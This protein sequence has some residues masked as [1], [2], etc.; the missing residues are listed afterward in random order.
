MTAIY[1]TLALLLK[2]EESCK[3]NGD[4]KHTGLQFEM[5]LLTQVAVRE[6]NLLSD[7]FFFIFH[8]L[9]AQKTNKQL[10]SEIYGAYV[11]N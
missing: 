5:S 4:S 2:V 3:L 6:I 10:N 11:M 8:M 9:Q 1:V 7:C